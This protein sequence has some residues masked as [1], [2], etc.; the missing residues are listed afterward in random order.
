M[1][2]IAHDKVI[3]EKRPQR[4][5]MFE[6]SVVSTVLGL[7]ACLSSM[8]MLIF[9]L[10]ANKKNKGGIIGSALGSEDR[11]YILWTEAQ[12][13]IY[14]KISLSDFLTLFSART[15]TWF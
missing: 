4:W 5:A 9:I 1:I 2:T 14:L 10:H 8:V 15:R 7:V 3:P 12:T 13:M 6:V 11:D